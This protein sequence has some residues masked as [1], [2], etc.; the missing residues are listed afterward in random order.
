MA[1]IAPVST[2]DEVA[3]YFD[4]FTK[5]YLACSDIIQVGRF[6]DD[7]DEHIRL[8]AQRAGV[9]DGD[10]VLDCGCGVGGVMIRL[11]RWFPAASIHGITIS[12]EQVR[13]GREHLSSYPRCEIHHG[14][15]QSI[16]AADASYDILL[17]CETL[18]YVDLDVA[19]AETSR[20]LRPGGLAYVKECL[21]DERPLNDE[22]Q[23]ELDHF[24]RSWLYAA[25]TPST[26]KACFDRHGFDVIHADHRYTDVLVAPV[27]VKYKRTRL[28]WRHPVIKTLP[29]MTFG[30]FVFRK[31]EQG[32]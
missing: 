21:A 8:L 5:D 23:A 28:G 1:E 2:P 18:G 14:D 15:F 25:R 17:Y 10:R 31:R 9:K 6:S 29:P 27:S 20:V 7:D 4:D 11:A 12:E 19:V 22:E 16:A 13:I 24:E 32:R 26:M 30:D 3:G